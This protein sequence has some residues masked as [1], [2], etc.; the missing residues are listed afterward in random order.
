MLRSIPLLLAAFRSAHTVTMEAVEIFSGVNCAGT[1]DVLAMYNATASCVEDLCSDISFG[2]DTYYISRTCNVSDRFAHTEAVFG[3]FTYVIMETFDNR[4]CASFGE[5]DVFL[6]S[7]SCEISSGFGDQSAI[8]SLFANGSAVVAL[9][10]NNAC[11]GEPSLYFELDKTA[12]STGSCQDELYRFYSSDSSSD[13]GSSSP[14]TTASSSSHLHAGSSRNNGGSASVSDA[15]DGSSIGIGAIIGLVAAALVVVVL[16]ALCIVRRVRKKL[17]A[18]LEEENDNFTGFRSPQDGRKNVSSTA[19]GSLESTLAGSHNEAHKP[20]SLG[21]LWDDE[22]IATA[23]I[24]REKVVAQRHLC[25]GGGGEV[26]LGLFNQQQVAIK[27][28]LP[29]TRKSVK[30]V[31]AFLAEVKLMATLD[32]PRIVKF[33]GVAWDSLTDLCVASEFMEGGDLRALLASYEQEG[34]ATGF[35]RSKDSVALL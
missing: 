13:V 33:V 12:L 7:G 23:R 32:H 18:E 2:N 21:G 6:A 10:P 31:N 35:D 16:V 29:D 19:P 1:P 25:R 27:M 5:A 4:S 15:S 22:V 14:S 34:H 24:P 20:L 9:Y 30:H 26:Y 11:G 3:D 17:E 8:T 28:L